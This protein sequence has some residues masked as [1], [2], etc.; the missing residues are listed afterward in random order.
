MSVSIPRDIVRTLRTYSRRSDFVR[1]TK[2]IAASTDTARCPYSRAVSG[3]EKS[4]L[5]SGG[6]GNR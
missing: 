1:G 3:A 2:A 5:R 6:I 4:R